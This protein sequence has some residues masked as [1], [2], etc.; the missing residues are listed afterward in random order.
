MSLDLETGQLTLDHNDFY[1]EAKNSFHDLSDIDVAES[2]MAPLHDTSPAC[3]LDAPACSPAAD[4]S[5][6]DGHGC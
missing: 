6:G 4:G 3:A 5:E 1:L 2:S